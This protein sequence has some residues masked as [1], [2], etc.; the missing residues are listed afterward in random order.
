M[1]KFFKQT[2]FYFVVIPVFVSC[3][4]GCMGMGS[5]FDCNVSSGGKCAPMNHIN[6][7]ADYGMFN[8]GRSHKSNL[9]Q[10]KY[11]KEYLPNASSVFAGAPIRSNESIQQMSICIEY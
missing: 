11:K 8:D 9:L 7:M 2:V 1:K 3:L 5:K 10:T 6:K 4:S